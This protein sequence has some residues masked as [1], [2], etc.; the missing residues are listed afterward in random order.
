MQ[1]S[2]IRDEIR[3]KFGASPTDQLYT[4]ANLTSLINSALRHFNL[5]QDWP[6]ME[7]EATANT[8]AD[9]QAVVLA[10]DIRRIL[11]MSYEDRAVRYT[12]P[13]N[14]PDF[15]GKTGKPRLY[16]YEA[17]TWKLLPT[18]DAVYSVTYTYMKDVEVTLS[19]DADV[20]ATPDY[21]INAVIAFVCVL[22]A[23]RSHDQDL[24]STFFAEYANLMDTLRDEVLKTEEGMLPR[25]TRVEDRLSPGYLVS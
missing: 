4:D 25:R 12:N 20:P 14:I 1:L 8:V 16:T 23:R 6:W 5:D 22:M 21:A 18:P 3:L 19:L 11:R 10:S 9:T 2:D 17:G 15:Y 13:R 24:I 7:M